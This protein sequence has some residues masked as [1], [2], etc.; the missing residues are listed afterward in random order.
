MFYLP[1]L[2]ENHLGGSLYEQRFFGISLTNFIMRKLHKYRINVHT[3]Y[4]CQTI[5][6]ID[7]RV[8]LKFEKDIR[9]KRSNNGF[10]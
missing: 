3:I 9:I 10:L 4:S 8:V 7:N 5:Y 2:Y 6:I 1:N